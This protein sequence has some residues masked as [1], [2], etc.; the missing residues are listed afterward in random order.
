M[1]LFLAGTNLEVPFFILMDRLEL[2]FQLSLL[3]LHPYFIVGFHVI[4]NG[5]KVVLLK[6]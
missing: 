6:I 3:R 2:E 1:V 5:I 4:E